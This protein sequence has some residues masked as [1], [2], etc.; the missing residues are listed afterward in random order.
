MKLNKSIITGLVVILS[1]AMAL[2]EGSTTDPRLTWVYDNLLLII[3][4]LIIAG[5]S[6]A[7]WNSINALLYEQGRKFDE[8]HGIVREPATPKESWFS[9]MYDKALDMIPVDKESDIDLGHD[10]DGIRELDNSLPPW[11]L[12]MFYFTIL[13]GLGYLYVYQFSDIGLSQTAEYEQEMEIANEKKRRFLFEQANAVNESNVELLTSEADLADG[14]RIFMSL[15][16]SCHGKEG[17]GMVGLGPNMTD[18]YYIH[19]G[20]I[21]NVFRTVKYGVPEKG[22]ISW[23]A[24][25]QPSSMQKV[26]SYMVSLRGNKV[27]NG[28]APEGELYTEE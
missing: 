23:Q 6:I 5:A 18:D 28:K 24:Q 7:I 27:E 3:G 11:W 12:Y 9:R 15:C 21:K 10:Y 26:A 4:G 20:G 13:F 25:L 22:M 2:A 8:M 19:G 16:A 14:Q 1:P 17:E